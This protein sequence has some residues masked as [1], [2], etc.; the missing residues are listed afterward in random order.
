M[1]QYIQA[2]NISLEYLEEKFQLQEVNNET[3]FPEWLENLPEIT[4]LEK[5]YLNNIKASFLRLLKYPPLLEN[6]VKMVL[7]SPLLNLAGFFTEPFFVRTE[8]SIEICLEDAAEIIRGRIDILVIQSQFWL[9]VIESKR[10]SF[11]LSD[12]IPQALTYMLTN[13]NPEK[14]S[15]GLVTNGSNFIFLKLTQVNQPKYALYDEF[16]LFKRENQLYQI[17]QIF[18]KISQVLS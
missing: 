16:S 4:D 14:S 10:S 3:F 11:S 13:P 5:Q 1:V 8:E 12:Y 7:L 6:A 17:L 2:Q 18:K 15:F 9:L